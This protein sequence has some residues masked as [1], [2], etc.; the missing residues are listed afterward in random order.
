MSIGDWYAI[1][2]IGSIGVQLVIWHSIG[3]FFSIGVKNSDW[4]SLFFSFFGVFMR[5]LLVFYLR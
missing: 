1:G 4:F 5:Y 2:S 3:K